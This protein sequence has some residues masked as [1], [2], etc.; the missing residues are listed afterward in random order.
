[1][2]GAGSRAIRDGVTGTGDAIAGEKGVTPKNS[3]YDMACWIRHFLDTFSLF[4][5]PEDRTSLADMGGSYTLSPSSSNDDDVVLLPLTDFQE[6]DVSCS[7]A[8]RC[9]CRLGGAKMAL[10]SP[11]RGGVLAPGLRIPSCVV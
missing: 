2:V 3:N 8:G 1:M 9:C 4:H 7:D 6:E 10:P 5:L 11:G